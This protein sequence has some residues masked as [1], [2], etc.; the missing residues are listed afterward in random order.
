MQRY[1]ELR[2]PSGDAILELALRNYIE[3]R[4]KT[5]DP[6]SSSAR[7]SRP[8]WPPITPDVGF[9]YS[10]VTFSHTPYEGAGGRAAQIVLWRKSCPKKA[11]RPTGTARNL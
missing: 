3:M 9:L 2:K 8:N 4:D 11:S 10:Q 7:K 5:G 1:T 6:L